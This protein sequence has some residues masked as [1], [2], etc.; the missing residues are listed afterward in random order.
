MAG[1]FSIRIQIRRECGNVGRLQRLAGRKDRGKRPTAMQGGA[2][3]GLASPAG[4]GAGA[5]ANV[6]ARCSDNSPAIYGWVRIQSN[7]PS[8]GRDE[9]K[10]GI[11]E[12]FC[13]PWTG[14]WTFPKREPSHKWLGYSQYAYKSDASA[15]TVAVCKDWPD[16]RIGAKGQRPCKAG[17]GPDWPALPE[18]GRAQA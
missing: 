12:R 9:R 6:R 3:A 4:T 2:G 7:Q 8:P 15:A 16:A 17:P 1:L 10:S 13:R 14:L 5:A 18:L 11:C